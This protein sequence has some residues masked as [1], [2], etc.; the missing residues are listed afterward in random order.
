M[1]R[2]PPLL[3]RY[4]AWI[5]AG[6]AAAL[7]AAA[8]VALDRL[9]REVRMADVKA[10]LAMLSPARVVLAGAF[11]AASYLAL[12]AYDVLALRIIGRPLPWRTAATA[13]FTSY[14]LSH[15]LGIALLTGGSARYRVYTAAGLDGPDVARVI[16]LASGTFWAGVAAVA[17]AALALHPDTLN[18]PGVTLA[19]WQ[20]QAIG[21][22]VL[23][24][25]A[26]MF[27][28]TRLLRT[29]VRLFGFALPLPGAGQFAAQLM[30]AVVD[31]ACA[32][33]ALFVLIPDAA[34][35]LWPAF[36]LAYSLGI[37]VAVITHVP[38]GIGVFEAVVISVLPGDRATLL[39]AL[40]AYRVIYYLAPLALGI[41]LLAFHEGRRQRGAVRFVTGVE[42]A[43]AAI[44]PLVLSA[45]VFAGGALLLLSGALPSVG[46]R[47]GDL[48]HVVPL[49]FIEA[50]H[51][52]ASLV[53]TMLLLLAP[54]LYRRLDGAN[55]WARTLLVAGAL[56]SLA[57]GID[58]EEAIV[59]LVIAGLLQ[60]TRGA[61]YRRTA[62]TQAP[63]SAGWLAS[64]AMVLGAT[65]WAGFFAFRYVPYSDDLW[66]RFAVH[67]DAPRFLRAGLVTMAVFGV[68]AIWRLLSPAPSRAGPAALEQGRL[69][70][71]LAHAERTDAMLALTGDKSFLW[72][73][74]GDAFVMYA[75]S[76]GTWA[77]M[78]D[79]VGPRDQWPDLMWRL[80]EAADRVQ[81]RLLLYEVSGPV[82][83]LAIGMGLAIVKFGEE[84]LVDLPEFDLETPRVRN[85][86]RTARTL[87]RKGLSFRIVPAGAMPL[88]IDE[89]AEVSREWLAAKG[90]REKRFSLG[91]FDREYMMRF[92]TGIV[93]LDGRIVAFA[94]LWTTP[95]ES[96][97]SVDLMRHRDEAPSGTMD[98]L[99]VQ[100]ILWAKARGFA[101]FSL[102]MAPLSGIEDRRLA[103]AWARL[104]SFAF[105][106]GERLYGFRGLRTYKEKYAPRWEPRYVAGPGGVGMLLALRDV[107]RLIEGRRRQRRPVAVDRAVSMPTVQPTLTVVG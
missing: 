105:R 1:R 6:V 55:L 65:A 79:P 104:A 54:G 52:A 46:T 63:F 91:R 107:A 82:L 103:P 29:P 31:L 27:A 81:A 69:D 106:H 100:L 45:A 26:G 86:R 94:N 18:L 75:P 102:G 37:V 30:V 8:L 47:I 58:Y 9:T 10:A 38:G 77:M 92:D 93:Q 98:F 85:V 68:V 89:L 73:P 34:P 57:K 101:R 14:T 40:L 41:V 53:G 60:W 50:S 83:D 5:A 56:F 44:A 39:A 22:V 78:G 4:R 84:A 64:V 24:A 49:P 87:E 11:T 33:A 32:S 95:N 28:A 97:A 35:A 42:D 20:A 2:I 15:N 43:V 70:V 3:E 90:Q 66:W 99:F 96:E 23:C 12:T 36:I 48:A 71:A 80:R 13:S 62:L 25:V 51:L 67:G 88:V 17:G 61:F 16:A 7:L 74:E 72:S 19:G 59:C 21:M 76:G